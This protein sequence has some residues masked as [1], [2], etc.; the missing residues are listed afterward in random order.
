MW[1]IN[2]Y[3]N[4]AL[5]NNNC[6]E[7]QIIGLNNIVTNFCIPRVTSEVISYFKYLDDISSLPSL[8]NRPA[9]T[10]TKVN[11]LENKVLF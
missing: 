7:K 5:N 3:E 6:L 2:V 9:C 10:S 4:Y 1:T 8:M 11:E